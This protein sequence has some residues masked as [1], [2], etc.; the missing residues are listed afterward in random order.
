MS[1]YMAGECEKHN[2]EWYDKDR[3]DCPAC[4]AEARLASAEQMEAQ[5][6]AALA[7]LS[8][9]LAKVEDAARQAH[10]ALETAAEILPRAAANRAGVTELKAAGFTAK[11]ALYSLAAALSKG[12]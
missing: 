12:A 11:D 3:A 9:Q 1:A 5:N 8:A 7:S 10:D 6:A 2:L 4:E